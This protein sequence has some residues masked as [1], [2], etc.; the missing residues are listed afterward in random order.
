MKV[1]FPFC[2]HAN[3]SGDG[4]LTSAGQ[5]LTCCEGLF[6]RV[7][8]HVGPTGD[9]RHLILRVW[10]QVPDG[11]LVLLMCEV[12][13]GAVAWHVFDPIREL[14]AVDLGQ[15]LEP[16]DQS[17]GVR[18]IFRFDLAGGIQTCDRQQTEGF[19]RS[20]PVLG[21]SLEGLQPSGSGSGHLGA[22][23]LAFIFRNLNFRNY[24]VR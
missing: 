10:L 12:D 21:L 24:S 14:D 20:A 8:G 1:P 22:P 4:S 9:E 2:L 17:G 5:A 7:A 23:D 19:Q 16:G 6:G 18:D 3:R 13:G 15:G 11:V